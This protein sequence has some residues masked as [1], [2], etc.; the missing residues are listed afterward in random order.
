MK[1]WIF[2][3]VLIAG[4]C[5][6]S[7][8]GSNKKEGTEVASK[9]LSN[10]ESLDA[11]IKAIDENAE[12]SGLAANSLSY[13][14]PSGEAVEVIAHLSANHEILK[15]DERFSEGEGKNNGIV[16]YY[17]KGKF[18]FATHEYFEDYT[19]PQQSK[20]VERISYYDDKGKAISTKE[21]RVN[22]EEELPNVQ[23]QAVAL[24]T[25][26]VDRAMKVL[27]QKDE[28]ATTFQGF[29]LTESL[30]YLIVGQPGDDGFTST[31]RIE[32][33]DAF[34][35]E[36]MQNQRKFL[37]RKCRVTFDLAESSGFVY[38]VYT[39]GQWVY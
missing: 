10:E 20:F 1:S 39:G 21:K 14:K 38:Q 12:K 35:I 36:A 5:F 3:G 23:F 24:H 13:S 15:L 27:D 22:F 30:N 11:E 16:T 31:L 19:D 33:E 6:V 34:I 17:M 28:Y 26:S 32:D 37:N 4:L 18:P 9:K 2:N 7:A 29:A 8:C 25:C